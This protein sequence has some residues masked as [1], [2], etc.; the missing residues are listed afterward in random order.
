MVASLREI[1]VFHTLSR[2]SA[3]RWLAC[4]SALFPL[5]GQAQTW[6]GS[7]S[8]VSE[9]VA[10]GVSL[11]ANRPGVTADISYR[12]DRNWALGLGLGS[13]RGQGG[14]TTEAIASATRWWQV[15]DRQ[16]LT[17]SAAHYAYA[18]GEHADRLRYSEISAGSVWDGGGSGQWGASLSLSPDLPAAVPGGYG[19]HASGSVLE[20]TWHRR[21]AGTLAVDAGWGRV[22]YLALGG[23]Y[24][25]ANAGLSYT[26]GAWRGSLARLYS[27][28]PLD[29]DA[30]RQRWVAGLS[31]S[32]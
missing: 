18:G 12:S 25:F 4:A 22:N 28:V 13:V 8:M 24:H 14:V 7:V 32:F 3:G 5:L 10:R 15:D 9:R 31:W 1:F 2:G 6:S 19:R 21:L 30:A 23:G 20:L 17:V 16:T 27:S 26:A 11:S 29:R